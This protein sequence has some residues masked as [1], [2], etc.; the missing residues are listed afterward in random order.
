[1]ELS[2]IKTKVMANEPT[3]S[4]QIDMPGQKFVSVKVGDGWFRISTY[5][6]DNFIYPDLLSEEEALEMYKKELEWWY[7]K[8]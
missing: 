8:L 2:V 1:M 6:P 4:L 3:L 5:W 7:N